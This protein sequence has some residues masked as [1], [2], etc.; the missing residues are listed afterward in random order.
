MGFMMIGFK[1]VFHLRKS[2][3]IPELKFPQHKRGDLTCLSELGRRGRG[4]PITEQ[5]LQKQFALHWGHFRSS[6]V[7]KP[8][9]V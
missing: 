5:V 8:G 2:L 3:T 9:S 6:V 7:M 4:V 1:V